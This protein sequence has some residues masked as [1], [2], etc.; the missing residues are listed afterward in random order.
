MA[1]D[2]VCLPCSK[3]SLGFIAKA[4]SEAESS[5]SGTTNFQQK[6]RLT[7]PSLETGNYKIIFY[8][9]WQG[10]DKDLK[11][12]KGQIQINDTDTI[13]ER[14]G[15]P[16]NMGSNND[17]DMASGHYNADNI[18]GVKNID[19]DYGTQNAAETVK[20]RRARLEIWRVA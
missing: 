4:S 15:N 19:I 2:E 9:E 3:A 5:Y 11:G 13:H 10:C 18:S 17:W 20:I 12:H 1:A 6:L 16:D 7:T 14:S 8:Y